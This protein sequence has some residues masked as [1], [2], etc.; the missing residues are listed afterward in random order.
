MGDARGPQWC[1]DDLSITF[2]EELS[3]PDPLKDAD[4][5]KSLP[6]PVVGSE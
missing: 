3:P 5:D 4:E 6:P 1:E 2:L